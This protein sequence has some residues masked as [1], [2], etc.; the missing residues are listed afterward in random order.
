M[1]C[2]CVCGGGGGVVVRMGVGG[3]VG[4]GIGWWLYL[5]KGR[6]LPL[7]VTGSTSNKWYVL[8]YSDY[9]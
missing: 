3:E 8:T 1:G 9:E 5:P 4:M 7:E 6:Q 2:V